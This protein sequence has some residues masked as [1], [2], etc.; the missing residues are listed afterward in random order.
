MLRLDRFA[1][2]VA[3]DETVSRRGPRLGGPNVLGEV[4]PVLV[5][6][7]PP[8]SP[9]SPLPLTPPSSK[10]STSS[11]SRKRKRWLL[12]AVDWVVDRIVRV[13]MDS[14]IVVGGSSDPSEL[15]L[16]RA[17]S[18]MLLLLLLL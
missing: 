14:C 15:P 6:L 4:L 3:C 10:Y 1:A 11:L 13:A 7:V 2:D 8:A 17:G 16:K 9:A 18:D 12:A 5:P